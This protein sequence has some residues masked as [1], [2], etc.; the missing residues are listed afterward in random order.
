MSKLP[1]WGEAVVVVQLLC[2]S[3]ARCSGRK[4]KTNALE[5][6]VIAGFTRPQ[7]SSAGLLPPV[8]YEKITAIQPEAA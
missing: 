2:D 3:V 8:E 6:L 4:N 7:H 1:K 5:A